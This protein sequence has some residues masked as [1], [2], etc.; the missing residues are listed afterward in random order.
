MRLAYAR[1]SGNEGYRSEDFRRTVS[2]VA[3]ED[4]SAWFRKVVD[5]T[6]ELEYDAALRWLGLRFKQAGVSEEDAAAWLGVKTEVRGGLLLVAEIPRGTPAFA[7]GIDIGDELVAIDGYRLTA[8]KL[9][10]QLE[11]YRPGEAAE[12]LVAR[13]GEMMTIP[14]TFGRKP[15]DRWKLEVDP[16]ADAEAAARRK[17]WLDPYATP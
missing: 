15:P 3:G 10:E 13:R 17:A 4:L 8:G 7:A 14:L 6:E 1:F 5:S 12:F 16:D 9:D 11:N 2:E